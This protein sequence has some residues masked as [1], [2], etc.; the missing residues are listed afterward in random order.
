MKKIFIVIAIAIG[1]LFVLNFIITNNFDKATR[2]YHKGDYKTALREWQPRAEQG[3]A[4]PQYNLAL[5][6]DKGQGVPQDYSI[7]AKWYKLSAEQGFAK[8]QFNLGLLYQKGTG[9]SQDYS[10]AAKWWM[11]SAE[12][13]LV[14]AQQSL[15][16]LYAWGDG[17][18]Q[19]YIR[20]HMWANL[21][22][23]KDY[24][25]GAELRDYV[26]EYMTPEQIT[27]AQKLARECV[28]KDYKGC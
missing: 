7:A 9:F 18:P 23:S 16:L 2:A 21:A 6:Y 25:K 1:I 13:G 14:S 15:G 4:V 11:L 28:A 8:A 27:E 22:A 20:A 5:L 3:E 24:E 26:T 17:V 19:D 10:K 12:Q